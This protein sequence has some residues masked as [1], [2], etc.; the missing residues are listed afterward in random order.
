[1]KAKNIRGLYALTP[2]L[3]DTEK[4]CHLVKASLSGGASMV[5]YRNKLAG[6]D[7]RAEQVSA[8]LKI[9]REHH[10]P[11]IINDHLD[12]CLQLDADGVHLGAEDIGKHGNL[13][14]ARQR[15]GGNKILG[16]SCY[17]RFELAQ[18]AKVQG[19]DYVA[20]G[21]CFESGTKPAA[22][23]APLEL[24]SRARKELNLPI[25]AIGGITLD[26]AASA[27]KA[28]ASSIAV[29]GAL[30]SANNIQLTALDV[31]AAARK[32]SNLFNQNNHHDLTQS[33]V[34]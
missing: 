23:N 24:I 2:D 1:M 7:L 21:A 6:F 27:I 13:A 22:A 15:L 9:S 19:A 14:E 20:F 32:F 17:N 10:I 8:L 33:T 3:A 4:L 11:L 25:V 18:Q 5:Q 31:E 26:N 30:F 34:V 16:V 12:L 29:I 28:G